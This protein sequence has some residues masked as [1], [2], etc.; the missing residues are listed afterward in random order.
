DVAGE[1]FVV[2]DRLLALLDR[3]HLAG[4]N[5]NLTNLVAQVV[6]FH[7]GVKVKLHL[8]LLA[9]IRVNDI[10]LFH[11]WLPFT[12]AR[13]RLAERL[14]DRAHER[15]QGGVHDTHEDA[16]YDGE[17]DDRDGG[18]PQFLAGRPGDLPEFQEDVTDVVLQ[19]TH[20]IFPGQEGLEPTT[21]G[22][23]D[24]YSTN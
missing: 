17:N 22:F 9:R 20:V 1:E 18:A 19:T 16:A 11:G 5:Q 24:R 23:G 21:N 2:A 10:P 4:G 6:P 7:E 15:A 3:G 12:P 8:V 13:L 14:C